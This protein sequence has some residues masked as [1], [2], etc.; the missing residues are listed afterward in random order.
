M[1]STP[2]ASEATAMHPL[3]YSEIAQQRQEELIVAAERRRLRRLLRRLRRTN[4]PRAA[5][6]ILP[7]RTTSSEI[8]TFPTDRKAA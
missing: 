7:T 2:N 8:R 4:A 3:L 5:V 6:P 1:V